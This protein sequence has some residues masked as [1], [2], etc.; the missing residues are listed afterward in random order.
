MFYKSSK[1]PVEIATMPKRYAQNALTKLQRERPERIEEIEALQKH[2]DSTPDAPATIGDNNPPPEAQINDG[3]EGVRARMDDLLIEARNWADG[4]PVTSQEQADAVTKLRQ[5][6]QDAARQADAAR[7]AEKKPYDEAIA[8]IQARYNDYIAPLKNK[9]PGS[10]S[11]AVSALGNV[12]TPWLQKLEK[13]RLERERQAREAAEKKQAEALAAREAARSTADLEAMDEADDLADAA[14][15]AAEA[16]KRA[17]RDKAQAQGAFRKQGL[18]SRWVARLRPG[19]GSD[20]LV[21]F[22]KREPERVKEFLQQLADEQ[23]RRGVREIPGFEVV[24]ERIV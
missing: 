13:E 15:E 3:W 16:L 21:H 4:E 19:G 8:E 10:V 23:L 5:L 6:L 17:E 14:M 2:I 9:K 7:V 11:K 20:A 24:E 1:G 18:R 22:A 12:L